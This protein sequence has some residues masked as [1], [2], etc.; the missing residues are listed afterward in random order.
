MSLSGSSRIYISMIKYRWSILLT[1]FI[2]VLG[3]ILFFTQNDGGEVSSNDVSSKQAKARS[4][5]R[6]GRKLLRIRV[7]HK[8]EARVSVPMGSKREKPKVLMAEDEEKLLTDLGRKIL[9]EIRKALDEEDFNAVSSWV[10]KLAKLRDDDLSIAPP[11][12]L[13]HLRRAAISAMG[14][15]GGSGI[16]ELAGFLADNDPEVREAAEEQFRLALEDIDL[17]DYER[18]KIV[19]Q[20]TTV[21][22]S[23]DFLDML[24]MEVTNMRNSVAASTLAEVM[25]SGTDAAKSKLPD[26]I[27]FVTGEGDIRDQAALEKWL[28]DNPDGADDDD[29]YGRID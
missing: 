14:W 4:E 1:L 12:G 8:G 9:A 29:L 21:V 15:F 19:V 10:T 20:A 18:A 13:A 25:I 24:M 28:E 6:K 5:G 22:T 11:G 23:S 26:A 3:G 17:S 2:V 16:P 7:P 27:D